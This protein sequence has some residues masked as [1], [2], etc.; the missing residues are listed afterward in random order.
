MSYFYY[1]LLIRYLI[2]V[3]IYEI[4]RMINPMNFEEKNIFVDRFKWLVIF[5]TV[6]WSYFS[7]FYTN[8]LFC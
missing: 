3:V 8:M 6:V 2:L 1:L 5:S 7:L 4:K